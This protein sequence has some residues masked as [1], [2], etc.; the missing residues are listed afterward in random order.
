DAQLYIVGAANEANRLAGTLAAIPPPNA[1][2][3]GAMAATVAAQNKVQ[4]LDGYPT[5]QCSGAPYDFPVPMKP[6]DGASTKIKHVFFIVRE[7]KTFDFVMGDRPNVDGDKDIVLA[8]GNMENIYPN[9]FAWV[10]QFAQ[11][12]NYYIDAEQ[13]IQG[14]TWTAF[15]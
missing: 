10:S 14:H 6:E 4:D 7:N 15:G 5:V 13:S 2:M 11:M 9:A 12:D 8:P 1:T 3:L